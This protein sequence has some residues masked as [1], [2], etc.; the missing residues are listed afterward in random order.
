MLTR[1]EK[2][3]FASPKI[4]GTVFFFSFLQTYAAF[5]SKREKYDVGENNF[6]LVHWNVFNYQNDGSCIHE[7]VS[8]D[9]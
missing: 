6:Q 1:E 4:T 5:L 9:S 3:H 7:K 2:S 8:E